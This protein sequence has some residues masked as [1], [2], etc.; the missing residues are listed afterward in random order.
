MPSTAP[1]PLQ[2][3]GP[4]GDRWL[5]TLQ[6]CNRSEMTLVFGGGTQYGAS[7]AATTILAARPGSCEGHA[8]SDGF[9]P[10]PVA[11]TAAGLSALVAG[12]V[13]DLGSFAVARQ[14]PALGSPLSP[15]GKTLIVPTELGLLL[16][17]PNHTS[18]WRLPNAQ[19]ASSLH[20]CVV[21]STADRAACIRHEQPVLLEPSQ[22]SGGA[23]PQQG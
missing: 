10:V 17:Q 7:A 21:A 15:D 4:S 14:A 22:E 5:L 2:A 19:S 3:V 6:T 18:L 12:Q 16:A 8:F 11:W 1:W 20:H 9:T 23:V 13:V